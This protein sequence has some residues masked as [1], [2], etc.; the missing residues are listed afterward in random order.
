VKSLS[1]D[2]SSA[3][4]LLGDMPLITSDMI[5]LLANA[6]LKNPDHI[7]VSTHQGKRGN[8]V[9]WPRAFFDELRTIQGDVGARHIMAA[10]R[11]RVIEVELGEAASLDL[12]T[13]ES[14]R[15]IHDRV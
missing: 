1:E 12:D 4:I 10:N 5:D 9:L 13:P 8:P 3:L 14:V 15:F 6:A 7:I 2:V 11:D